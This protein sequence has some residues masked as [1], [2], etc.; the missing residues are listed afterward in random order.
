[1]R[2]GLQEQVKQKIA[3]NLLRYQMV[4][5]RLKNAL[6][7]RNLNLSPEGPTQGFARLLIPPSQVRG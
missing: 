6:Q 5:D 2:T 7:P 4:V 3:G 1:M